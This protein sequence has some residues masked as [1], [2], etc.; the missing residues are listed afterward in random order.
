[1]NFSYLAEH[2]VI[3]QLDGD[4]KFSTAVAFQA[5]QPAEAF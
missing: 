3:G 5:I 1:M 2:L 4:S